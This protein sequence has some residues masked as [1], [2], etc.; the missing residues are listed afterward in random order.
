MREDLHALF[1]FVLFC[2]MRSPVVGLGSHLD[3]PSAWLPVARRCVGRRRMH[4]VG[5]G[6]EHACDSCLGL[7]AL[8]TE[9]VGR[10]ATAWGLA[11]QPNK[12]GCPRVTLVRRWILSLGRSYLIWP[13]WWVPED[14]TDECNN[15]PYVWSLLHRV[16][17]GRAYLCYYSDRLVMEGAVSSSVLSC[18]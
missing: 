8:Q 18:H 14:S 1:I 12:G 4:Y 5:L 2:W 10:R 15:A 13:A 16:I 3:P 9:G 11:D 17:F 6:P 7:P